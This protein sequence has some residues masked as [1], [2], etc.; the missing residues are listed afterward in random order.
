MMS[1]IGVVVSSIAK[2]CDDMLRYRRT[3]LTK[4][5]FMDGRYRGRSHYQVK[6]VGPVWFKYVGQVYGSRVRFKDDGQV[7]GS[8]FWFKYMGQVWGSS[9]LFKYLGQ[10]CMSS[11]WVKCGSSMWVSVW[12]VSEK[13]LNKYRV[14]S[15]TIITFLL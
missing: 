14:E 12:E 10:V 13:K 4:V 9:L 3:K 6:C 1:L 7:C 11:V 8:K 15:L 5:F 2:R